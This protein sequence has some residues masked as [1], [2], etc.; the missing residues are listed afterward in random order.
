MWLVSGVDDGSLQGG[1]QTHLLLEEVG[2]LGHLVWQVAPVPEGQLA[3]HLSRTGEYLS[4]HEVGGR[5]LHDPSE[6]SRPVHQVVL[7]APVAVALAVRV[8]LVDDQFLALW[9]HLVGRLHGLDE[10]H[11]RRSVLED[12]REGVGALRGGQLGVG[13]V[14][15]VAGAVGEHGIHEV[16]LDL[17]CQGVQGREAADVNGRGFVHEVPSHSRC[18]GSA[19]RVGPATQVGVDEQR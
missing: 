19:P 5:V 3:A 2:P 16:G 14:D 17:G 15:V 6:R 4:G 9:K 7:V 13:V 11:L 10:D 12:H 1:L 8:V 18:T